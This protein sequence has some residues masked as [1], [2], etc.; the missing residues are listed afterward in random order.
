MPTTSQSITTKRDLDTTTNHS[1]KPT[2]SPIKKTTHNLDRRKRQKLSD[3]KSD[4]ILEEY[5][6]EK[7]RDF[8]DTP[9]PLLKE[10]VKGKDKMSTSNSD[11][12]SIDNENSV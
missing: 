8:F 9:E 2:L 4:E 5:E 12:D 10:Y 3:I 6:P 1:T 7:N 11:L